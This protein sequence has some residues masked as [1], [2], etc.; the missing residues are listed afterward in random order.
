MSLFII[1]GMQRVRVEEA[2]LSG[3]MPAGFT[4]ETWFLTGSESAGMHARLNSEDRQVAL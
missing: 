1:V 2:I 3:L 4:V